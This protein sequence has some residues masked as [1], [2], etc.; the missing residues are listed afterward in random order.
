MLK[1]LGKGNKER[2]IPIGKQV[3][4]VLWRYINHYRPE[5]A[6]SNCDFLFL[7]REGRPLA[8]DRVEKIM[9]YYGKKAR[10][11]GV[12]CSSEQPLLRRCTGYYTRPS[13]EQENLRS[14][15]CL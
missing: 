14:C 15:S 6:G 7:T 4:R 13:S 10:L 2:L 1:V 8:K 12:R 3:Q 9:A 5:P 11:K